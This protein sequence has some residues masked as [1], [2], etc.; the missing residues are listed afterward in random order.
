MCSVTDE[1]LATVASIAV[2][3]PDWVRGQLNEA[4]PFVIAHAKA[5]DAVIVTEENRKGPGTIDKNL[6]IPN[7]A[8]EHGVQCMKFFEFVRAHGWSF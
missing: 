8:G 4:D 5:D 3:H 1:E 7:V 6:K 2:D